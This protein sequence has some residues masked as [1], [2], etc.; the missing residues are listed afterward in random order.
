M[1]AHRRIEAL[2]LIR[3]DFGARLASGNHGSH[4][5][6]AGAHADDG[7]TRHDLLVDWY[8][9]GMETP[10]DDIMEVLLAATPRFMLERVD[11]APTQ[12]PS[13]PK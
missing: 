10:I 6:L 8:A 4:A 2:E 9:T 3:A 1:V 12:L 5:A 11:K 13:Y 7:V